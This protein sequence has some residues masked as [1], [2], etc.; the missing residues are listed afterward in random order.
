MKGLSKSKYTLF[1]QCPKALWLRTYKP[2]EETIDPGV[3]ARFEKGNEVGDLAMQLF[4]PFVE[5][6]SHK[7]DGSLDLAAMIE[8]TKQEIEAGT[9]VIC[10]ASFSYLFEQRI[11]NFNA[12]LGKERGPLVIRRSIS[13]YC[14]VD[15]LRKTAGGWAIYEVKSSSSDD[16]KEENMEA[17]HK[18]A[19]DIAYQ[20]WV[21]TQCGIKVTG[22]YLVCLNKDY[23]LD[24]ELDIQ[25]LFRI[26]DLYEQVENELVKV[27]RQVRKAMQ[28][29]N[30]EDEPYLDLSEHCRNPYPCAFWNY[31]KQK[32]GVPLPSVFDVYGGKGRGGFSFKK[33]LQC[34]YDGNT[35]Y[36]SLRNMSLG[37][38]QNMQIESFLTGQ[39]FINPKGIR[40]FL[41]KLSYPLYFLDFET[42]QDVVPKYQGTHPY[43]QITFQYSLHI[44][45]S[46][47]ADYEHREFL[48]P[49]DGSD[50]RR[51]LA[52]QLCKD[53][54]KDVCTLAYNKMFE[55]GRIKELAD[56]YPDLAEH[57][58]N[59]REHIVDLIDPFRAGDYY[60][61]AMSGSF[62][63]KSVLPA[64]FPKESTLDYHNLDERCQNGGHA[65][66]IF[67][68]I[69]FMEPEEAAAS[70]EALL[71]YCELDTW[72]MVKVWEKLRKMA[73]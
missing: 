39:E 51:S 31:C 9:D 21:L 20:K 23:V 40:K 2:E 52:E 30:T 68:R 29:I 8:R 32:N 64:L 7:E 63:I 28:V 61:P 43:Q 62:S 18:Y 53:I 6:T 1:C 59:I 66:T 47:T 16:E 26:V 54:P 69:Q 48:A 45:E 41:D 13:N 55:C 19:V 22:T 3:E 49:S 42:M 25:G 37:T 36:E 50:P 34:Y 56:L 73:K 11:E 14:A 60:V 5:V 10:E 46:E 71:R 4:G 72:A 38:I 27:P 58:L 44:K 70:R 65:M 24:G 12:I 67:P 15:I 17:F 33:K 35:T 57:L